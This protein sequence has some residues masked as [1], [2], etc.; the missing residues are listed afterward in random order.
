MLVSLAL[1]SLILAL[2]DDDESLLV[3]AI[4]LDNSVTVEEVISETKSD[5]LL[6]QVRNYVI[7]GW[8]D[9]RKK[10]PEELRSFFDMRNDLSVQENLIFCFERLI[11]PIALHQRI[12]QLVHLGHPGII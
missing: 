11:I 8:P 4:S 3:A 7:H 1:R 6:R 2:P 9:K 5:T 10:V 12:L